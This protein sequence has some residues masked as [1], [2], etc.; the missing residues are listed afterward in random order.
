MLIFGRTKSPKN[1]RRYLCGFYTNKSDIWYSVE[2]FFD[3]SFGRF[4]L[5]QNYEELCALY[6]LLQFTKEVI[7][8]Y[9]VGLI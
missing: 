8:I 4:G 7:N 2:D 6:K 3:I 9:E 1:V 5:C